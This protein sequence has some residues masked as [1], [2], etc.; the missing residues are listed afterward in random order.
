MGAR[1]R[2]DSVRAPNLLPNLVLGQP[3]KERALFPTKV[4]VPN[5][6]CQPVEAVEAWRSE[7]E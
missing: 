2:R 7:E 1:E 6:Y 5:R 3:P 4:I